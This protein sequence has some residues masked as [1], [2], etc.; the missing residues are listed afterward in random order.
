VAVLS[1]FHFPALAPPSAVRKTAI[2]GFSIGVAL[3]CLFGAVMGVVPG[4]SKR[5]QQ[6]MLSVNASTGK[7]QLHIRG[8]PEI[9]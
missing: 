9:K 6:E 1:P 4:G 2:L 3:G 5:P 7:P 8:K